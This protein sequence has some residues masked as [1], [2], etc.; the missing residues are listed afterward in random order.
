MR[1]DDK[2]TEAFSQFRPAALP[3][4]STD[5][6]VGLQGGK[7]V[8]FPVSAFGG[9]GS[10]PTGPAGPAG[11]T[12][13]AGATGPTGAT[14]AVGGTGPAGAT[15]ATGPAGPGGSGGLANLPDIQIVGSFISSF[16]L[17]TF[18]ANLQIQA[19]GYVLSNFDYQEDGSET[20]PI[21]S[22]TFPGVVGLY[23]FSSVLIPNLEVLSF[24]DLV[25]IQQVFQSLPNFT[26]LTTFSA[27]SLIYA[28]TIGLYGLTNLA[29]VDFSSLLM[30][31]N[32]LS[33]S[34]CPNITS[35]SFPLLKRIYGYNPVQIEGDGALTSVSFPSLVE[36]VAALGSVAFD[37]SGTPL[38]ESYVIGSSLKKMVGDVQF[39][40]CAFTQ[41]VVDDLLVLFASLDGTNGTTSYD[42]SNIVFGGTSAT[43]SSVGLAAAVTLRARGNSVITN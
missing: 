21:T 20:T 39:T 36:V 29:I 42:N 23:G 10:G 7:N 9:G 3:P 4:G 1:R 30:V 5:V 34:E 40:S 11:D 33:I 22:L 27:P 43:P 18:F 32:S 31:G 14:G 13:P 26:K 41:S 12:G 16:S 17:P 37:L 38:L 35:L 28:D 15:G 19:P 25:W 6:V 24:P 2:P 8:R